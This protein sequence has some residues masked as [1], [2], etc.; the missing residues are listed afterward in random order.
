MSPD[1]DYIDDYDQVIK[2]RK[3]KT[4]TPKYKCK[5]STKWK[6]SIHNDGSITDILQ[7]IEYAILKMNNATVTHSKKLTTSQNDSQGKLKISHKHIQNLEKEIKLI[8]RNG[9]I[10]SVKK[11]TL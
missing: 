1:D 11:S 3:S 2:L 10:H 9:S 8:K 4:M 7:I 6:P 5:K